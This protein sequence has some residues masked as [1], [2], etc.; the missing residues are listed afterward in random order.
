MISLYEFNL[1]D[2][3]FSAD[4]WF[5]STCD[6][7][8][9]PLD[10]MDFPT[11]KHVEKALAATLKRGDKFWSYVKVSGVFRHNWD[12]RNFPFDR[13][14]LAM[15]IEHT[16]AP[17]SQ[18]RYTADTL[19]SK[20]NPEIRLDSWRVTDFG[21]HDYVY[22]YNT[23]FGDPAFEGNEESDY[24]RM[25]VGISLERKKLVGFLK[26]TA[27]VYIAFAF[28]MLAFFLGGETGAR[29]GLLVGTLFAVLVNQRVAEAVLGRVEAF[30]LVDRIHVTAMVFLFAAA[31]ASLLSRNLNQRG[32]HE[33]AAKVDRYGAIVSI[34]LYIV[35]NGLIIWRAAVVG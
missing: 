6:E 22:V 2:D 5:W 8:I 26:L 32:K 11:A 33:V 9:R 16:A 10:A 29:T 19:G 3:S 1:V 28:A 17:A 14:E 25:N 20:V 35:V 27:G 15:E 13:H 30:T 23:V 4:F 21:V 31:F 7:D 34:V 12:V 18:F 24:A